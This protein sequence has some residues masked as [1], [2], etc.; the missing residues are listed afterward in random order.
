MSATAKTLVAFAAALR[1]GDQ[2][3]HHHRRL[4][5]APAVHGC[6]ELVEVDT[7]LEAES[8]PGSRLKR[9]VAAQAELSL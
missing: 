4:L 3:Q 2:P 7:S 8:L 6:T 5:H 1:R 9:Y